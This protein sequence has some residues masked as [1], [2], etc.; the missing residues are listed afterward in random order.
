MKTFKT[1]LKY[2]EEKCE[3]FGVLGIIHQLILGLLTFSLLV[4][5]RYLKILEG[6]GLYGFMI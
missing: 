3:F 5:K 6:H 4:L 1:S 2:N